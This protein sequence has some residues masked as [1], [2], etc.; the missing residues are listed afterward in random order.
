MNTLLHSITLELTASNTA[1]IAATMGH[2]A[3]ALFLDLVQQTDAELAARLHDEPN[4]RPF[5][6]SPLSGIRVQGETVALRPG[7]RC[8]LRFTL[9]DGGRIWQ[10]LSQHFL[11]AGPITLRL[12]A[13][14]FALNRML[15]TPAADPSG[16]AG[17]AD[18][19]SLAN[20]SAT[21]YIT[22]R[23]ASPTAFSVG[24]KQM[25][26][27]PLPKFVWE[28]LARVW[29]N[30]AP[31]PLRVEREL[32]G[33]FAEH[34]AVVADYDLQTATLHYPKHTQKGF[35]GTCTYLVQE[36]DECAKQMAALAEFARYS[37]VGYKTTMGMGQARVEH[38]TEG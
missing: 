28:S 5:T 36:L 12:G 10:C 17:Y 18:W 26:L 8:N 2:Q 20:T 38:T 14:E 34:R 24:D 3:H 13:A 15:T 6:V 30:Y 22:L 33:Q 27:F 35:L 16:W 37:G 4:Y 25:M 11:E 7:L 19:Q 1:T 31:E 21:R 9:L 29:N 23:F 32:I